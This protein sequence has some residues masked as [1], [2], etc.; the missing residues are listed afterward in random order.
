M[1]RKKEKEEP[2]GTEGV[3]NMDASMEGSLIFKDPVNLQINGD[4][5]GKLDTKGNLTIGEHADVQ[6][7][8]VGE[9]IVIAGRV[10]GQIKASK[11]LNIVPPADVKG[12]IQ[13]PRLGVTP[14][15]VLEGKCRMLSTQEK[16]TVKA[17]LN[18]DEIARYLEVETTIVKQWADGRKI[19][20]V[21]EEDGWKFDRDKIDKW[22]VDEKVKL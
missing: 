9:N 19:P 16:S 14:G 11:E 8:I 18:I 21:R 13:T 6:A 4:F 7:D 5:K 20:A 3:L 10:V 17:M 1:M 12:D 15:A 22:I 2:R